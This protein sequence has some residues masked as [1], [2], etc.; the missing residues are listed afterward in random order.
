MLMLWYKNYSL[1]VPLADKGSITATL[2]NWE[3]NKFIMEQFQLFSDYYI[4]QY[5]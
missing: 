3:N 2:I 1:P 5:M 4:L